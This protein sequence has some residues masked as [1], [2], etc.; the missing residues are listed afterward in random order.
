MNELCVCV[1]IDLMTSL[2]PNFLEI[3]LMNPSI[4]TVLDAGFHWESFVK[5]LG[6]PLVGI[7]VQ[8]G[9]P[10]Q[11][12]T[13]LGVNHR[14][15]Q[16]RKVRASTR[17][18]IIEI[19]KHG[20]DSDSW[21]SI[22]VVLNVV[23]MLL[24][25][26]PFLIIQQL[27]MFVISTRNL[28]DLFHSFVNGLRHIVLPA[29]L[30]APSIGGGSALIHL[31]VVGSVKFLGPHILTA[32]VSLLTTEFN[33]DVAF[34]FGNEIVQRHHP[35]ALKNARVS[36]RI[37]LRKN[38]G[39]VLLELFFRDHAT[40]QIVQVALFGQGRGGILVERASS[41]EGQ[42]A[43]TQATRSTLHLHISGVGLAFSR[44][45]P[46]QTEFVTI[47]TL[48]LDLVKA[49]F[50]IN[51]LVHVLF[52]FSIVLEHRLLLLRRPRHGLRIETAKGTQHEGAH[53][54][55]FDIVA[56]VT[57]LAATPAHFGKVF[58]ASFFQRG[59]LRFGNV[60]GAF[61]AKDIHANG[62]VVVVICLGGTFL[63][64]VAVV[65]NVNIMVVV[66]VANTGA[67]GF[68]SFP[69]GAASNTGIFKA[70]FHHDGSIHDHHQHC[71]HYY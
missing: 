28:N 23:M 2:G 51:L 66:V 55:G 9:W 52:H 63:G 68:A 64:R 27:Q 54:G 53:V 22:Q 19:Q 20:Q 31:A 6:F 50:G 15:V 11:C 42:V 26:L 33:H 30:D 39:C 17:L 4:G 18:D 38:G 8:H 16:A 56:Q 12:P 3:S 67:G 5:G 57:T 40:K 47:L 58:D 25:A 21:E 70:G 29:I 34:F 10:D 32:L 24:I 49:W 48:H 62:I 35:R 14:F 59:A 36:G 46:K 60:I 61:I 65:F 13:A 43:A 69:R 71:R 41:L 37:R 45:G 7:T 1:E 44:R